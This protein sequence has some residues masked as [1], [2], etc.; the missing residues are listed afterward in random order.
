MAN[1][2]QI[3]NYVRGKRLGRNPVPPDDQP[4]GIEVHS[5]DGVWLKQTL[6]PRAGTVLPQHTHLWDHLTMIAVGSVLLWKDGV[7][8]GRY[9]A[10]S[11]ITIRAGVA[12]EV[13][14]LT[15]NTVLWCIHGLHSEEAQQ[16]LRQYDLDGET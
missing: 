11:G 1:R 16:V 9:D 2:E 15:D 7:L 3:A 10:P 12:H 4:Y 8:D 6:V 13:Q 14:T 5:A